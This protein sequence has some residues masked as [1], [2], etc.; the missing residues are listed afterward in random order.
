MR[1]DRVKPTPDLDL[2]TPKTYRN[3]YRV[4]WTRP[5]FR[6]P[7]LFSGGRPSWDIQKKQLY[8]IFVCHTLK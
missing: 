8:R 2:A 1:P 3:V 5:F 4:L 6:V 7:V